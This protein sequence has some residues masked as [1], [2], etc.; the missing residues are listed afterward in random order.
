[1]TEFDDIAIHYELGLEHERLFRGGVPSLEFVRTMELLDRFLPPPPSSI[2]DIGG[3]TGVYAAPLARK[4]YA[5]TLIDPI[6]LHIE[7]AHEVA[8]QQPEH[9][10]TATIGDARKLD[11]PS[12]HYD[13]ALLFG[14]LYHLTEREDRI[15]ALREARRILKLGGLLLAVGISR[16]RS[17]LGGLV[18]RQLQN[19][20]F[21]PIVERDL[22]DGQHRNPDPAKHPEFFTTAFFHHPDELA[23][24]VVDS[25][26]ES[27]GL[28]AIEG[29][30]RIVPWSSSDEAGRADALYATRVTERE[31][32]LLGLS[33]HIMAI[34]RKT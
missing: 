20:L 28:Y 31:P 19:P 1:M 16:F 11:L 14:P 29:P 12:D 7:K 5:V 8:A 33:T 17:L 30:G 23:A 9:P 13:V 34:A 21:R 32:S 18:E 24:E 10:F 6:E 26:L 15:T 25:G 27:D 3:G 2:A 22:K 4:Q